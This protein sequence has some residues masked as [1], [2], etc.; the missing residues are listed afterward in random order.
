MSKYFPKEITNIVTLYVPKEMAKILR[1]TNYSWEKLYYELYK[2]KDIPIVYQYPKKYKNK[3]FNGMINR[4]NGLTKTYNK[5][6]KHIVYNFCELKIINGTVNIKDGVYMSPIEKWTTLKIPEKVIK[7]ESISDF[8][9]IITRQGKGFV[10]DMEHYEK[11]YKNINNWKKIELD[12]KIIRISGD[13]NY[14]M[15][16]TG[17]GNVYL[18][19]IRKTYIKAE[20]T[21]IWTKINF[22]EKVVQIEYGYN[23]SM[24]LLKSRKILVRGKNKNSRLGAGD[25]KDISDWT[26]INN[27]KINIPKNISQI[28]CFGD[29]SIVLSDCGKAF[30]NRCDNS[31]CFDKNSQENMSDNPSTNINKWSEIKMKKKIIYIDNNYKMTILVLE[32]NTRVVVRRKIY[33]RLSNNMQQ[34]GYGPTNKL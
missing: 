24:V 14:L 34:N 4:M 10:A 6:I 26:E 20:F 15:L 13:Q 17:N 16:L 19:N 12:E 22:P 7:I 29:E 18:T 3:Y 9:I 28:I 5:K 23:H 21:N 32:D 2:T 33:I 11:K 25:Y 8:S 31:E 1:N 27:S 30:V